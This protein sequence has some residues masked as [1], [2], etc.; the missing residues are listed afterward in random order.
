[1]TEAD[2]STLLVVY[3]SVC[4]QM[5]SHNAVIHFCCSGQWRPSLRTRSSKGAISPPHISYL[6]VCLTGNT[7]HIVVR[8]IA[9]V[10]ILIR[11]A[12]MY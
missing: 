2:M 5:C 3:I 10:K 4:G 11:A 6:W 1:M 8:S 7:L 9:S 12:L